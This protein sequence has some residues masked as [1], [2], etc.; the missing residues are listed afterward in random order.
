MKLFSTNNYKKYVD[1]KEAVL[2]GLP[3]DNGLF[4]PY[5]IPRLSQSFFD[6]IE[7]YSLSEIAYEVCRSFFDGYIGEKDL[8]R[9]VENSIQFK[10]PITTLNE[11]LSVLELF[12]GPSLAFKDFGAAFMAGLMSYFNQGEKDDL[13]IL[14]ATSG[15]TGGAVAAGF[16]NAPGIEVVILYPNNGVTD[17]QERQLTCLGSNIK[18]LRFAEKDCLLFLQPK[19]FIDAQFSQAK[20]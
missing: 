7:E 18:A 17:L 5:K 12:H 2:K 1:L 13:T 19:K 15:D 3:D 8:R 16:L 4:M 10:A 20:N 11:N 14:V 6:N 9:I